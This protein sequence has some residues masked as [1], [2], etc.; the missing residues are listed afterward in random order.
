MSLTSLGFFHGEITRGAHCVPTDGGPDARV[1]LPGRVDR[2]RVEFLLDTGATDGVM[3]DAAYVRDRGFARG[4]V[5]EQPFAASDVTDH[6]TALVGELRSPLGGAKAQ[7]GNPLAAPFSASGSMRGLDPRVHRRPFVGVL[8]AAPLGACVLGVDPR[9]AEIAVARRPDLVVRLD[10]EAAAREARQVR[11]A[12][13]EYTW[14]PITED[15][16]TPALPGGGPG[17]WL[18]DTGARW[19]MLATEYNPPAGAEP[20]PVPAPEREAAGHDTAEAWTLEWGGRRV[21]LLPGFPLAPYAA[22]AG[23]PRVDGILG[24]DLLGQWTLV[25]DLARHRVL[26]FDPL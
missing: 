23:V 19:S 15:P 11:V 7:P 18:L 10:R 4:P 16:D 26:L 14:S 12:N 2:E 3:L 8:G 25:F 21:D 5:R 9:R 17:V 24:M 1:L 22:Q 20:R 13:A 6:G